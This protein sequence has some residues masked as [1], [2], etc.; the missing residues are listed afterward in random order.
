MIGPST[1]K[2]NW[3]ETVRKSNGWL[4]SACFIG[5]Y[6]VIT[7]AFAG[8]YHY[9]VPLTDKQYE[10]SRLKV[11]AEQEEANGIIPSKKQFLDSIY[12]SIVTGTTLGY[13]DYSPK[14][15]AGKG[16]VSSHVLVSTFFFALSVSIIFLKLLYPR[17]TIILSDKIIYWHQENKLF[18]RVINV[19]RSKLI[20]PDIRIVMA[21][22][23]ERFGIS[24]H[25]PMS[26][27]DDLPPLGNHDF[28][29]SF[30]DP[31]KRLYEQIQLA[32]ECNKIA[33]T[34]DE[35]SRFS[36]KVSIVGSYGFSSYTHY[37][38]YQESDIVEANKFVNIQYPEK[39]HKKIRKYK[40]IPRFWE[41]FHGVET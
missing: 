8:I 24:Q 41:R 5:L 33:K 20:N 3:L 40:S 9:Y 12:F 21:Q 32:R 14:N 7:F 36:I 17:E 19:N 4:L 23:T 6:L 2:M 37:K 22:H 30:K 26:K 1:T 31:T 28:I 39:F 35:K 11:P 10:D 25:V 16:I 38:K 15:P 27:L 34:D 18:F 29:I 13:G